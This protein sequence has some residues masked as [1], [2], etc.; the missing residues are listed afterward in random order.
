VLSYVT[1]QLPEHT[2]SA[3][4]P[5]QLLCND[6]LLPSDMTLCS[7]R[8]R[9]PATADCAPEARARLHAQVQAFVWKN[10][11]EDMVLSYK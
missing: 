6:K 5:L 7:V 1:G 11:A 9:A 10:G 8:E 3:E 4:R 2:V